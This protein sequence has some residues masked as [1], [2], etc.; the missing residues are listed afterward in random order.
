[1]MESKEKNFV[2]NPLKAFFSWFGNFSINKI[3]ELFKVW[4][5]IISLTLLLISWIVIPILNVNGIFNPVL[6][7]ISIITFARGGL[8]GGFIGIIGGT[9]G[10][11]VV[12]A[13]LMGFINKG[14]K[15]FSKKMIR[16]FADAFKFQKD[17]KILF[18]ILL[19]AGISIFFF[20]FFAAY[21]SILD[22]MLV[23][24]FI[25][26]AIFALN[27]NDGL[28]NTM[29][30]SFTADSGNPN[31]KA[32]HAFL[33]GF[34]LGS[35]N[36]IWISLIWGYLAYIIGFAITLV[37]SMLIVIFKYVLRKEDKKNEEK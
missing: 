19:G 22:F 26:L 10:K 32:R 33:V 13:T 2:P 34:L 9:I 27:G 21:A 30:A 12:A 3:K 29:A 23:I 31:N 37:S 15:S 18:W 28:L 14:Y 6:D 24:A 35:L 17:I 4:P 5:L 16:N 36:C 11:M 7:I 8:G 1:M 25:L 20:N